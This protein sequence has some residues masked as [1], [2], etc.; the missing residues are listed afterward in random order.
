MVWF[1][2]IPTLLFFT[3][4]INITLKIPTAT[5][6]NDKIHEELVNLLLKNL[7]KINTL[8]PRDFCR[9]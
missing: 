2:P 3:L 7:Q 6:C 9:Q 1:T 8:H 4:I 5:F